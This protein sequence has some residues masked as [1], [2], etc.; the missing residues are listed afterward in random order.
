MSV[1]KGAERRSIFPS[2]PLIPFVL[3]CSRRH[4]DLNTSLNALAVIKER[5][6]GAQRERERERERVCVCV[7]V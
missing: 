3:D 4:I 5:E 2:I 6:R 1:M 7:C